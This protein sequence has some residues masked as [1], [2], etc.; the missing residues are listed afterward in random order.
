MSAN[1]E[2]RV[3]TA[4]AAQIAAHLSH[5]DDSFI[6]R[7]SERV[8]IRAYADKLAE[9]AVRFEAWAEGMLIGLVAAYCNDQER[10]TAFITSV[11]VL[12]AWTGKGI[13]STLLAQCISHVRDQHMQLLQLEVASNNLPALKLYEKHGFVVRSSDA[14]FVTATLQP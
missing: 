1:I 5:C 9:N 3:N 13:A 8:D 12:P 4:S 10:R 6:P 2:Y 7:L 14:Q 11:S